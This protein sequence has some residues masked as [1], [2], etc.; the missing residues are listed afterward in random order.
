MI[1]TM[2]L[3]VLAAQVCPVLPQKIPVTITA[4]APAAIGAVAD[5][6]DA[7]VQRVGPFVYQGNGIVIRSGDRRFADLV[8]HPRFDLEHRCGNPVFPPSPWIAPRT[9]PI[10]GAMEVQA[11]PAGR[12]REG[13]RGATGAQRLGIRPVLAGHVAG[14]SWP[15]FTGRDT[16]FLGLMYPTGKPRESRLVAFRNEPGATPAVSLAIIPMRLQVVN[17]IPGMH[18]P[19]S[20]LYL[21]ALAPTEMVQITLRM[22]AAAELAVEAM[23]NA[24]E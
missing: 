14:P 8:L 7:A 6:R 11:I 15:V 24:R 10:P 12:V 1:W 2:V 4:L 16:M 13:H 19:A 21:A 5:P 17:V 18:E 20:Y 23:L 9:G 22:D 3:P